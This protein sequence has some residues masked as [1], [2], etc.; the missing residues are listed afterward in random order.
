MQVPTH[1]PICQN[2]LIGMDRGPIIQVC[3][4]ENHYFVWWN[5]HFIEVRIN[6]DQIKYDDVLK[7]GT[8]NQESFNAS[9]ELIDTVEQL[10][11]YIQKLITHSLFI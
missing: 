4:Q 10:Y 7:R 11:I 1:C 2:K 6:D 9:V 3:E 5:R 8:L